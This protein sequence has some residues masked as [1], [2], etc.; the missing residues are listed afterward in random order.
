MIAVGV[1]EDDRLDRLVREFAKL[2]RDSL[3]VIKHHPGVDNDDAIIAN[4]HRDIRHTEPNR[5]VDIV[6]NL[7]D[8][9]GEL[10]VLIS[11]PLGSVIRLLARLGLATR[12]QQKDRRILLMRLFH[13]RCSG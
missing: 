11:Q 5:H 8:L 10:A 2:R 6:G 3:G 13:E 7:D 12:S 4:D 9:L 1:R